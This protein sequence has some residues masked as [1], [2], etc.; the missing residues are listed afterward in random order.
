MEKK[1][2]LYFMQGRSDW[3][4]RKQLFPVPPVTPPLHRQGLGWTWCY[5]TVVSRKF[6]RVCTLL[7][8][9]LLQIRRFNRAL[10][11]LRCFV[12]VVSLGLASAPK[13]LR[14][15][16]GSRDPRLSWEGEGSLS[17]VVIHR[18]PF[19]CGSPKCRLCISLPVYSFLK[20]KAEKQVKLTG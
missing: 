5:H 2:R 19:H 10:C 17:I 20:C 18:Y 6:N 12:Q 14:R 3:N 4:G 13:L 15:S 7:F 1:I 11:F 16:P 9:L 8:S